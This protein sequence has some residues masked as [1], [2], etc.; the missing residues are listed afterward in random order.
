MTTMAKNYSEPPSQTSKCT[1]EGSNPSSHNQIYNNECMHCGK[2]FWCSKKYTHLCASMERCICSDCLFK[3]HEDIK[4]KNM[5]II[6]YLLE[7]LQTCYGET[8]YYDDLLVD[9]L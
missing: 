3:M 6:E 7:C 5:F 4:N 1:V 8:K 2:M 9:L